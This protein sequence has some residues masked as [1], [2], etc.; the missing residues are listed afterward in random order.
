MRTTMIVLVALLIAAPAMAVTDVTVTA[1]DEGSKV[2]SIN[3]TYAGDGRVRAFALKVSVDGG[4]TI[5]AVSNYK[6]G[7]S[8]QYAPGLGYGI[9]PG[10]IDLTDPQNPVWNDPVAPAEDRGAEGTGLGTSTV[11]LEMGSLYT[12]GE[13]NA[14][15]PEGTL[16]RLTLGNCSSTVNVTIQEEEAVRGGV[17]L[18]N[19]PGDAPDSLTLTGCPVICAVPTCWDAIEC[20][21]Q[22]LG[23]ASCDGSINL[24]DLFKVKQS[25]LKAYGQA[26][27]NCCA[28]FDHIGSVNLVDLFR[29]KTN[30]LTTGHGG[31]LNQNCPE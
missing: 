29:I 15:A 30:W 9:F 12:G 19:P 6:A 17:V 26:G 24:V 5:D 10:S 20:P 22:S 27:Y 13:P 16:C 21:G 8:S 7:E 31:N 25:W 3:Y 14:P 18:E 23:D 2:V 11:I 28:N 1:T 4:A